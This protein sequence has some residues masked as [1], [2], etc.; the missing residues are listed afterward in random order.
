MKTC[1]NCKQQKENSE[2]YRN[3]SQKDGLQNWCK[4]CCNN[5]KSKKEWNKAHRNQIRLQQQRRHRK[6]K[7][8]W[9]ESKGGA[10]QLCGYN[11]CI[12][13]LCFHHI[14][15]AQKDPDWEKIRFKT[16][17]TIKED[18]IWILRHYGIFYI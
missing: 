6:K 7:T 17:E 1:S 2:F 8:A 10:C 15:P 14:D 4:L 18:I 3:K 9:I 5:D 12:Q 11:K 16:Y 13:A